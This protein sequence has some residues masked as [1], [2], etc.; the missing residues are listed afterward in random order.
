MSAKCIENSVQ[1]KRHANGEKTPG[2]KIGHGG[3]NINAFSVAGIAGTNNSNVKGGVA[4]SNMKSNI[5][6]PIAQMS[7]QRP[8]LFS[9][10]SEVKGFIRSSESLKSSI[11]PKQT[12]GNL[13][14]FLQFGNQSP[15]Q[16]DDENQEESQPHQSGIVIHH[17]GPQS[18]E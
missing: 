10:A 3:L 1:S 9:A 6:M 13:T 2:M 15:P 4:G 11:G 16:N 18:I 5:K 17:K 8:N 7:M 14:S 12:P